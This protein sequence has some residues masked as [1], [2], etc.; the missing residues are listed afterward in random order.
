MMRETPRTFV[1]T[2]VFA[3]EGAWCGH[4]ADAVR[5]EIGQLPGIGLCDLDVAAGTLVV[6]ASAPVDRTEIVAALDR[7]GCRVRA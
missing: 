3:L 6:T 2:V 1:G 4:N 5:T 7:L